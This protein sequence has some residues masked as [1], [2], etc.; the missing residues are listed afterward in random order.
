[1]LKFLSVIPLGYALCSGSMSAPA[2]EIDPEHAA[3][4]LLKNPN[5]ATEQSVAAGKALFDRWCQACHGAD[6][7]AGLTIGYLKPPPNLTDD[8]WN[9]GS[10]D[11][12]I[13]D[14]I[15]YGVPPDYNMESWGERIDESGIW[16]LVN[17]IRSLH[18][19]SP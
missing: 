13:F 5:P 7:K 3:A 2:Q 12:E 11:G 17:Y 18:I 8:E 19:P 10:T 14:T 16:N 15:Q 6:G 1:M 4:A 9:Y